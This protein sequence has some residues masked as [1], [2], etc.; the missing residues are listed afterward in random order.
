MT[1][2]AFSEVAWGTDEETVFEDSSSDDREEQAG[3]MQGLLAQLQQVLAPLFQLYGIT[4]PLVDKAAVRLMLQDVEFVVHDGVLTVTNRATGGV[5][6]T[7]SL[8]DL[9]GGTFTAANLPPG[10]GGSTGGGTCTAFTYSSWSACMNGMQTRTVVS[11]MPAGCSGG[12]PV[13]SQTCTAGTPN[14]VTFADVVTSCTSCHGLTSNTTVFKAGGYTVSGRSAAA[15]LTTVNNMVRLGT[16][17]APG[18]TAQ[19]YADY[20]AT[21]P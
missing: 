13:T 21:A 15:W 17:L 12:S 16:T 11:A 20:L 10:P 7:G 8:H 19:N 14:P 9:A 3:R 5:I 2:A 4:D 18:T 1:D 6:F